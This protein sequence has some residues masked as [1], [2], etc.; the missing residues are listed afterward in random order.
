MR[1]CMVETRNK[2]KGNYKGYI[3]CSS[4][5]EAEDIS[6]KIKNEMEIV[7]LKNLKIIIKHG[8]SEFYESYP[9]Y[10]KIGINGVEEMKYDENWSSKEEIIDDRIPIRDEIDK[11]IWGKYINGLNLSD[12]LIINN[13]INYASLIGDIHYKKIYEN[14]IKPSFINKILDNQITFRNKNY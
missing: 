2:I 11:K 1:K 12:F 7:G 13:W 8:C 3:Y 5:K 14:E 4:L 10:E 9:E 6:M